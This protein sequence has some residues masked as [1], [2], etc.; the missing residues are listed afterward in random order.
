MA[1]MRWKTRARPVYKHFMCR[2]H[3]RVFCTQNFD[4]MK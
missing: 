2:F 1:A 3:S 4:P